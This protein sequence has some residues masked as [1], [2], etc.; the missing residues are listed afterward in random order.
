MTVTEELKV[1]PDQLDTFANK[2]TQ[3]AAEHTQAT[4]TPNSG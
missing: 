4:P 2:L 3:L 1:E